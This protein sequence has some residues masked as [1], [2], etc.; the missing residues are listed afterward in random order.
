MKAI[1][2]VI[3]LLLGLII[4]LFGV[5]AVINIAKYPL[6]KDYRS[7]MKKE[8]KIPGLSDNFIPQALAYNDSYDTYFVSGYDK[9]SGNGIVYSGKNKDFKRIE[10]LD[11]NVNLR[12]HCGGIAT[13][14]NYIWISDDENKG[15]V[16]IL[17]TNDLINASNSIEIKEK[18]IASSDGASIGFYDNKIYVGEFYRKGNYETKS[19]HYYKENHSM[20]SV[21]EYK[22]DSI[23]GIG[24]LVS[25]ISIPDQAQG[26]AINGDVS[27]VSMSYG[28]KNSH[29]NS[30]NITKTNDTL[31][32]ISISYIGCESLIKEYKLPPMSEGIIYKDDRIYVLY[33]SASNKYLFGK[34]YFQ[35]YVESI[36]A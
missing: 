32:G 15:S 2:R 3:K 33:E 26:I 22:S 23:T 9:K 31:D 8:F 25:Y 17:D 7:S 14:N 19:E 12:A 29:L 24:D 1:K 28:L 18:F 20:V 11:G 5:I 30:Y 36:K 13:Y 35:N 16:Y 6:Y 21:Y 27:Y 4:F 10:I 34:L